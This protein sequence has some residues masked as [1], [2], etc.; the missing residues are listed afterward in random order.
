MD[1]E[2]EEAQALWGNNLLQQ[3]L[4]EMEEIIRLALWECQPDNP[5]KDL[6]LWQKEMFKVFKL[7]LQVSIEKRK[8][9]LDLQ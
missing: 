2:L 1:K 4:A 8:A 3:I 5:Q 6:I 9:E 7:R